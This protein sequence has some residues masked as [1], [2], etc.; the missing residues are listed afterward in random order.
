MTDTSTYRPIQPSDFKDGQSIRPQVLWGGG[1]VC[2]AIQ[3]ILPAYFLDLESLAIELKDHP[4]I[5]RR[6][7]DYLNT[8]PKAFDFYVVSVLIIPIF[9]ALLYFHMRRR[10]TPRFPKNED[11]RR[12]CRQKFLMFLAGTIMSFYAILIT[13]IFSETGRPYKFSGIVLP[14]LISFT[15]MVNIGVSAYTLIFLTPLTKNREK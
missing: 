3:L 2:L 1:I 6:V 15:A 4:V 8:D 12:V 5:G 14:P 7:S 13:P 11:E 10:Y 9:S